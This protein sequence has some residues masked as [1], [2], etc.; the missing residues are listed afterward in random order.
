MST[1]RC[2]LGPLARM[3]TM[4]G[5]GPSCV[6]SQQQ[7]PWQQM[8]PPALRHELTAQ[9]QQP[10]RKGAPETAADLVSQALGAA[11]SS[12][13]KSETGAGPT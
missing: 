9:L 13:N 2:A 12:I 4:R 11:R 10:V 1:L 7:Q 5:L 3:A 6:L 8:Q